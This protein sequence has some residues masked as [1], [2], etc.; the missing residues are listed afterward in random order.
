MKKR[1]AV[2]S[3]IQDGLRH[4]LAYMQLNSMF[5]EQLGEASIIIV[6]IYY[7]QK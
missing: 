4:T 1:P 6:I 5:C 2:N 7:W 3:V